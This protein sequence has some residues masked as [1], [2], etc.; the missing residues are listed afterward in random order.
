MR[1]HQHPVSAWGRR[2]LAFLTTLATVVALS[3]GTAH[4]IAFEAAPNTV[5]TSHDLR[6][7]K[8][9]K[10]ADGRI[11]GRGFTVTIT[12]T[13]RVTTADDRTGLHSIH[14]AP[15]QRLVGLTLRF[16][17]QDRQYVDDAH[18][19]LGTV[20]V[21]GQRLDTPDDLFRVS[22]DRTLVASVPTD[23]RDIDFAVASAGVE[24]AFSLNRL[25]RVGDQPTILYRD[26]RGPDPVVAAN[27]E[28]TLPGPRDTGLVI[29]VTEA[30]ISYFTPEPVTHAD[31]TDAA[32]LWITA[33]ATSTDADLIDPEASRPLDA[34]AVQLRLPDG[35]TVN[36]RHHGDRDGLL[37]GTYVFA[38]PAD[39][40]K[41]RLSI[42]PG[43][44]PSPGA[45]DGANIQ[46]TAAFDLTFDPDGAH[47]GSITAAADDRGSG[48]NGF[49]LDALIVLGALAAIAAAVVLIPQIRRRTDAKAILARLKTEATAQHDAQLDDRTLVDLAQRNHLTVTGPG[50]PAAVVHLLHEATA[51]GAALVV[52]DPTHLL[53]VLP[54]RAYVTDTA[55]KTLDEAETRHA[56]ASR[57]IP[58]DDADAPSTPRVIVTIAGSATPN[59]EAR[60][61][62]LAQ[63]GCLIVR[64]DDQPASIHVDELGVAEV[65]GC[66]VRVPMAKPTSVQ[67]TESE[68]VT[69]IDLT[70]PAERPVTVHV[71]GPYRILASDHELATGLRSKARELLALLAVH[72]HGI[73]AEAAIDILLPDAT[74]DRGPGHLRTILGNLRATLRDA[75]GLPDD[76]PVIERT[77]N[78]YR[79]DTSLVDVDLWQFEDAL[80]H[81]LSESAHRRTAADAYSGNLL[82]GEYFEWAETPREELRRRAVDN[83]TA[84]AELE[85]ND[86]NADRAIAALNRAI[87]LDPYAEPL[88]SAQTA[89]QRRLGRTDAADRTIRLLQQRM[90]ELN[91][92]GASRS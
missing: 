69:T 73:T 39:L 49:G 89:L 28:Q 78:R 53:A 9:A 7:T 21:D 24:Q 32:Y 40:T 86:G 2:T 38:V 27:T 82:D 71:L 29:G 34:Q 25:R 36:A 10:P 44:I 79:L 80:R 14:A 75:A 13:G 91:S 43:T 45:S 52:H 58:E 31:K 11:R 5:V 54:D 50:A 18:P 4:A 30:R 81:A 15:G 85:E 1:L 6:G 87:A 84:L 23:A 88:Y 56:A 63:A 19:I 8:L 74:P 47:P 65:D 17:L 64:I 57:E 66:R 20:I 68:P 22:G 59:E 76:A 90:Q 46:G 3:A 41:A 26:R 92:D 60:L 37:A 12:G 67:P 55:T 62:A 35:S 16:Q 83:L 72:R 61:V 51:T 42:Q 33:T 48:G 70:D 77:G